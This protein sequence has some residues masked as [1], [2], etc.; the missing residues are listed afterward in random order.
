MFQTLRTT[1]LIVAA[2]IVAQSSV[3]AADTPVVRSANEVKWGAPPPAFPPGARFAFLFLQF[4][5]ADASIL[6]LFHV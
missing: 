3:V 6:A 1:V 2:T 5:G 4:E